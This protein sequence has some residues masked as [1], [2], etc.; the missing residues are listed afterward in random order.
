MMAT[1]HGEGMDGPIM[2]SEQDE[3]E[4]QAA[5]DKADAIAMAAALHTILQETD[6]AEAT[7]VAVAALTGTQTGRDYLK[8]NPIQY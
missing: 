2:M 7:R 3:V 6:D 4:T 5:R 1:I 8:A